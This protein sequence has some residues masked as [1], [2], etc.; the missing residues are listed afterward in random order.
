[1]NPC[2]KEPDLCMKESEA[3]ML[4]ARSCM[5][6]RRGWQIACYV[7]GICRIGMEI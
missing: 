1:M 3:C 6:E 5:I 7:D 4:E 2:M